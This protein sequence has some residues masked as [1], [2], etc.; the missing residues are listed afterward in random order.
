MNKCSADVARKA[1][2]E[3]TLQTGKGRSPLFV[4]YTQSLNV[5][6]SNVQVPLTC[7]LAGSR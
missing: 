5:L 2:E 7:C 3:I 6:S 1:A 4:A